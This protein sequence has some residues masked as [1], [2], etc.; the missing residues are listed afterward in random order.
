MS[1]GVQNAVIFTLA[2]HAVVL[3][4]FTQISVSDTTPASEQF[5]EVELFN[6]E[7]VVEP[8]LTEPLDPI[9]QRI[10]EQVSNLRS[11]ASKESSSEQRSTG[12]TKAE[13]EAIDKAVERLS[14]IHI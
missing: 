7:D 6:P 10:D 14:L 9:Q 12:I 5:A 4:A 13:Q 2:V 1:Q 3:F 11:D 8:E